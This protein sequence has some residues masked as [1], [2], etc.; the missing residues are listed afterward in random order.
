RGSI[1]GPDAAGHAFGSVVDRRRGRRDDRD[2]GGGLVW[3]SGVARGETDSW[4]EC[5]GTL[6]RCW[7]S[8]VRRNLQNPLSNFRGQRFK[9][10]KRAGGRH[11]RFFQERRIEKEGATIDEGVIGH[12]ERLSCAA[13][14]T[15]FRQNP[16][17]H[18][19]VRLELQ[20][21][22]GIPTLLACECSEVFLLEG[23]GEFAS[24]AHGNFRAI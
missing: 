21:V 20:S 2:P 24:G 10:G 11:A 7:S 19:Q 1:G 8:C 15:R 13:R 16:L 23:R 14:G 12:L 17:I 5:A 6:A 18:L 9:A 3:V 4:R 22:A